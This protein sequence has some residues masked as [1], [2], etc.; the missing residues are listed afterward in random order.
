MISGSAHLLSGSRIAGCL[1]WLVLL[2]GCVSAPTRELTP[3]EEAMLR[4]FA[5]SDDNS[6]VTAM[7]RDELKRYLDRLVETQFVMHGVVV[8]TAGNPIP[9]ARVD[10]L[11]FNR[12]T[13]QL[14]PPFLTGPLLGSVRSKKDGTFRFPQQTGAAI[15][16]DVSAMGYAPVET[17]RRV[18]IFAPEIIERNDFELPTP[19]RPAQFVFHDVDPDTLLELSSGSIPIV[20]NGEPVEILLRQ[21]TPYGVE[22]GTGDLRISMERGAPNEDGRYNWSVQVTVPGGELQPYRDLTI[23]SAPEDGYE[24]DFHFSM[25]AD[26]PKWRHRADRVLI[27]RLRDETYAAIRLR[28]RTKGDPTFSIVG[29]WNRSGDRFVY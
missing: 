25:Q 23:T 26:D 18:Y 22:S 4:E 3:S 19:E 8:D 14:E 21:L 27:L 13:E 9:N 10:A 17:S 11:L 29:S 15:M 2:A 5:Q 6:D 7:S 12:R 1:A 28:M 24:S 20:A 16:V